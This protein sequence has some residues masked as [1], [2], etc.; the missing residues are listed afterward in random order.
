MPPAKWVA[1]NLERGQR[2]GFDPW[3]LTPREVARYETAS[4]E[5]GAK[6]VVAAKNPVDAVWRDRPAAPLTPVRPLARRFTGRPSADKRRDIAAAIAARGSAA[7]VLTAPESIAWLLNIRGHDLEFAPLALGFAV[8]GRDAKV[9]LAMD[10]RKLTEAAR[11]HLGP[12]V[13]VIVPEALGPALD[14]LGRGGRTVEIDPAR[15]PYWIARRLKRAGA[16]IREAADPCAA[17]KAAKNRVEL[18]GIRAAHLRD[19]AALT[20]FLGWFDREAPKGQLTET[21]AAA[22]VD[23]FRAENDRFQGLSFP[24]ISGS[25]PNGAIVHYRATE[26]SDRR[27]RPGDVFLV[28]SGAQY[29]DGT[30]DVTRTVW[31]P[32]RGA[33]K[34]AL[35]D[36]YTR[37]LKGNIALATARFPAGTSGSQLDVLARR[38]L[39]DGGFE[40]DHGTGHGVGHF[41]NVHEGPQRI[42]QIP[43][44][45]ALEPGMVLSDE[46]GFYKTGAFGIRIETLLVVREDKPGAGG[47]PMRSFETLTLAPIDRRL[48]EPK[49]LSDSERAWLNA[50][51]ARVRTALTPLVDAGTRAWLARATKAI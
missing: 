7:A 51:H 25:G 49:M 23:A 22:R 43:N 41:L 15:V 9:T 45:V 29:L 27:I 40:Y 1:Q 2:L 8:I 17:P 31:V 6:L 12:E 48:I 32:G 18:G 16:K 21:A 28:D 39:W 4:A 10:P 11:R 19:G 50:Y 37:V 33:P 42:S 44:T 5:C 26:A 47:R 14:R 38:A 24:T 13:R 30:T 34:A 36:V 3:L 35:K 20:R 46:P